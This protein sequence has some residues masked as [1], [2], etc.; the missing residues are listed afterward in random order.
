MNS[1]AARQN[2][3]DGCH[4]EMPV[5]PAKEQ[6]K[7]LAERLTDEDAAL[8]LPLMRTLARRRRKDARE[9]E[10]RQDIEDARKALAE[11]GRTPWEK[12]KAARGL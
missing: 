7:R 3:H 8:V 6:V 9:A 12:F 1:D 4:G 2:T 5:V 11:P 10:D